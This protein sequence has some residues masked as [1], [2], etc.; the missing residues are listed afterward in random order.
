M[1]RRIRYF[2]HAGE[3]IAFQSF[4]AACNMKVYIFS[5]EMMPV[6]IDDGKLF[7][8]LMRRTP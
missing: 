2:F 5:C 4:T 6:D 3:F 7:Y 8:R 1:A